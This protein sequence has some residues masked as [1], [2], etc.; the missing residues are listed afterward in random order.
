MLKERYASTFSYVDDQKINVD[1]KH[2]LYNIASV[3]LLPCWFG[4]WQL[5]CQNYCLACGSAGD[6]SVDIETKCSIVESI[7]VWYIHINIVVCTIIKLAASI[8][9]SP[10]C[11]EKWS[12]AAAVSRA[13]QGAVWA[14]FLLESWATRAGEVTQGTSA[15]PWMMGG[16]YMCAHQ[17]NWSER[18]DAP[19]AGW[20]FQSVYRGLWFV[21]VSLFVFGEAPARR[22][23]GIKR[24][25]D[26][27]IISSWCVHANSNLNW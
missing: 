18:V 11:L 24:H 6:I 17:H 20:R 7:P 19:P 14:V 16:G 2:K 9:E 22:P 4:L 3:S 26:F 25:G 13:L 27:E 23:G 5:N 10:Q 12:M 1:S 15:S 8:A 21:L